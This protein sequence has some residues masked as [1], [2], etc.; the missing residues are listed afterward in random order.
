MKIE[1]ILE[2]NLKREF[3]VTVPAND[4]EQEV[5]GKL[6]KLSKSVKMPGFR[7][8]KVPLDLVKKKH[9]KDVMGEV[10]QEVVNKT[11]NEALE[12]DSLKPAYQ[13]KIEIVEFEEGKD[14]K[15]KVSL[16]ILPE[17]PDVDFKKFD[18]KEYDP[19]VEDKDIDEVQDNIAKTQKNFV[20]AEKDTKKAENGDAVNIDFKGYLDGQAFA[21]GE[22]QGHQLE[23][24]SGAFIPGFEEQ[25][26]GSKKGDEKRV[27]VTFPEQYHSADLA[28]KETEFEVKINEVLVAAESKAD[29]EF[30]KKMG[31]ESLE[32]FREVIKEQVSKDGASMSRV[33]MKKELFD[34]IDKLIDIQLPENLIEQELSSIIGQIK[35]SAQV[36][37]ENIEQSDDEL[38]EE[39]KQLAERR[40]KLGLVIT[41]IAIKNKL[42]V[43][44]EELNRA[45]IQEAQKY[46]GQE[47]QVFEFFQKN[48]QQAEALKGPIVEDKVVDLI[49]EKVEPKKVEKTISDIKEEVRS[50][51]N[52]EKPKKAK[53]SKKKASSKKDES[54]A[55]KEKAT[56]DKSKSTASKSKKKSA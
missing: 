41:D 26:V 48:P 19:Q 42:T 31:F 35:Q 46:Q 52:D 2:E 56:S 8:G 49:V 7:P 53:S 54:D 47:Q 34:T 29:D 14:L 9:G 40:V 32:K 27:K 10:L 37:G 51:D 30:A 28:G 13:P 4:I 36:S 3:N 38:K 33:L 6:Q 16:E 17:I 21:G 45:I 43:S 50:L 39:Y 20:P 24:G 23:L 25:L 22:A 12:K 5:N 18:L 15:Y 55:K 1:K 44:Q 11:T